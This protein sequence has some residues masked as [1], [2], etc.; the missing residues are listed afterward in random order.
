M[1]GYRIHL[2][3]LDTSFTTDAS[4]ER[5]EKARLLLEE[6][7]QSLSEM[8]RN[9]GKEKLLVVLALGLADDFLQCTDRL[10]ELETK[11]EQLLYKIDSINQKDV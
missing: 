8:G 9:L 5:V 10:H 7:F 6:R 3:G 11:L 4:P 1:A 2:L